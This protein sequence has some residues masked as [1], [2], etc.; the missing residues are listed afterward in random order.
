MIFSENLK[1]VIFYDVQ[2]AIRYKLKNRVDAENRRNIYI[3]TP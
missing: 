2:N 1:N 3:I